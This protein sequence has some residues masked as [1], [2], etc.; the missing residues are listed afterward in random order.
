MYNIA[1]SF[2]AAAIVA[3]GL[4]AAGAPASAQPP[5]P[6]DFVSGGGFVMTSVGAK[7]NFGAHGGCKQGDYWG[8]VNYVDHGEFP[9][10]LLYHVTSTEIT[11]YF[12]TGSNVRD[13]CGIATTNGD[14]PQPVHFRVRMVD[15]E[16]SGAP[17]KFGIRLSNGYH[18]GLR[19]L[20]DETSDG[21][22]VNLHEG[23]PSTTG[24]DPVPDVD[25]ACAYVNPPSDG[26]GGGIDAP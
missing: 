20:G 4:V 22:N 16:E 1:R 10:D 23:N 13:I 8:H 25:A 7:G 17:D 19:S 12:Q 2:M 18:V 26:G 15:N 6:C 11:G 9:E 5:P 14:E 24:P 3:A 21:G